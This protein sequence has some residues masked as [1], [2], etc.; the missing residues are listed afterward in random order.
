[1]ATINWTVEAENWLKKIH[2]YIARDNPKATNQV[3]IDIYR[4]S[5]LLERLQEIGYQYRTKQESDIR[6]LLY[7]HYRVAYLIK[8]QQEIDILGVFHGT[9]EIER[10][11]DFSD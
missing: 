2:A 7:G 11:L 6:I 8:N 4:K 5:Q 3:I 1:M 9:M 10:Y